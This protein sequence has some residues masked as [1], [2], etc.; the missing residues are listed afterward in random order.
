MRWP[1][2]FLLF[3][4]ILFLQPVI[5]AD[6]GKNPGRPESQKA[7]PSEGPKANP[8]EQPPKT[9]PKVDPK[10]ALKKTDPKE[11]PKPVPFTSPEGKFTITLPS[12][13]ATKT[14]KVPTPAGEVD[15]HLFVVDRK[16]HAFLVSYN[17]Y[18]AGT[19]DPDPE[20]VLG[21]VVEATAKNLKG[22]VSKDEKITLGA[23]K[24]P[25][26]EILI[27]LPEKKG[28]YRGQVYLVGNRLYQVVVIGP[29]EVVKSPAVDDFFRSFR[30]VE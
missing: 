15:A 2:L 22:Q 30:L 6:E 16:T 27:E 21:K 5:R 20:K 26:H 9:D 4:C 10:D 18:K 23:K 28:L 7:I 29:A 8:Q 12:S 19:V 24:Y 25:G 14:N 13:P 17:D 3:S 11:E 1:L